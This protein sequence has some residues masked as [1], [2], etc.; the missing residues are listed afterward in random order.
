[1]DERTLFA[2]WAADTGE[3][4]S[5]CRPPPRA[6]PGVSW[7]A[8]WVQSAVSGEWDWFWAG[9]RHSGSAAWEFGRALSYAGFACSTAR[10]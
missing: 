2:F 3:V 8:F 1:V 4:L 5:W 6:L 10:T 9:G 7:Q